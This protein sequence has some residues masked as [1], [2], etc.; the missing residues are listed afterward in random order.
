MLERAETSGEGDVD[1]RILIA[2]V[3]RARSGGA[4]D[5]YETY[6][7]RLPW[8]TTLREI[9][10]AKARS[11]K[12]RIRREG[13]ALVKTIPSGSVRVALDESGQNL[14]SNTFAKRI[15]SWRDS[16]RPD[17]A[18]VLG[19]ADGLAEEIIRSADLVL[20][21]G[22]MTWPHLLARAMVMEQLYRASAILSG[23]PYHRE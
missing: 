14:S 23:H 22:T 10:A 7:G 3:G 17:L 5:L 6:T 8:P 9:A 19:G 20:A 1:M 4:H 13:E 21:L 2:A 16:G 18:F 12:E 11:A 15:A